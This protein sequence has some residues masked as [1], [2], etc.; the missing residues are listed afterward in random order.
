[1]CIS[2]TPIKKG[3]AVADVASINSP[4][5]LAL[6]EEAAARAEAFL[7]SGRPGVHTRDAIPA[8]LLS[9][10][11]AEAFI[12]EL[13]EWLAMERDFFKAAAEKCQLR[14]H[15]G[16]RSLA[17]VLQEVE[18]SRGSLELKY[19][20]A[21]HVLSGKCFEKG[22]PPFDDFATLVKLRN[23]LMHL[24]A[25]ESTTMSND[26]NILHSTPFVPS[27]PSKSRPH[28]HYQQQLVPSVPAPQAGLVGLQYCKENNCI[29]SRNGAGASRQSPR[30]YKQLQDRLWAEAFSRPSGRTSCRTKSRNRESKARIR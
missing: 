7:T 10:A 20:M 22:A 5:L 28:A 9:A 26:G 23:D 30:Q 29:D 3:T 19:L 21:S 1:M 24:K 13:A 27:R 17:D 18:K 12:N 15:D 11:A 16:L 8:I 4:N 2:G 14:M 25:G 6:A